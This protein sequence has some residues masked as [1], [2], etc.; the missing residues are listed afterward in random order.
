MYNYAYIGVDAFNVP[1][2]PTYQTH[3]IPRNPGAGR[4]PSILGSG[5]ACIVDGVTSRKGAA[6]FFFFINYLVIS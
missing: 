6:F 1:V 3:L 5:Y 4:L 2:T